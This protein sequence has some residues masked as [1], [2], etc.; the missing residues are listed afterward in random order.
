MDIQKS[1]VKKNRNLASVTKKGL[2]ALFGLS[3]LATFEA[4]QSGEPMSADELSSPSLVNEQS[5]SSEFAE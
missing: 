4:C 1:K 2:V 5:S 3:A